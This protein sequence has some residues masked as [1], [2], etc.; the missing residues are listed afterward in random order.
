MK[1]HKFNTREE[2]L[3]FV[4]DEVRPV[5]KTH[6]APLPAK[7]RLSVGF[8]STGSRGRRIGECWSPI[9]SSDK[10]AEIFIKPDQDN[11]VR[12]AGILVHELVHAAVGNEHGHKRPF[13]RV[14]TLM[15]LVGKMT[16]TT[17]GPKFVEMITPMLKK[18]GPLPHKALLPF[19]GVRSP[20]KKQGTRLLKAECEECGYTVRVTKKWAAEGLPFCGVRSH[21]R[22]VCEDA[23]DEGEGE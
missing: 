12:V 6:G 14:A 19:C 22:M 18:A 15:G 2:W 23:D 17:E 4:M 5:F 21:G 9:A 16:A 13:A 20:R 3:N 1:S 10:H 11:A 8:T 7:I